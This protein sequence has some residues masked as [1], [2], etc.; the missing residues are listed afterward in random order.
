MTFVATKERAQNVIAN[1]AKIWG[2]IALISPF[3]KDRRP[4]EAP[5]VFIIMVEALGLYAA[6][7]QKIIWLT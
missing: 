2:N 5:L 7:L 1:R 3:P 4:F 6:K